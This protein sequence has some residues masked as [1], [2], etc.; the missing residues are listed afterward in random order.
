VLGKEAFGFL[1]MLESEDDIIPPSARRLPCRAPAF[2]AIPGP[3]GRKRSGEMDV[4]Q[5]RPE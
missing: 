3:R 5:Q 4:G 1:A 2:D